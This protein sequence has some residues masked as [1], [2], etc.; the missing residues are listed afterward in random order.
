MRRL[1]VVLCV[2]FAVSASAATLQVTNANLQGWTLTASA[3]ASNL[4][5]AAAY[6]APGYETPPLGIGSVH[7]TIG[8]NGNDAAQARTNAHAGTRVDALTALSYSTFTEVDGSGGQSPYLI[9]HID[10]DGNLATADQD[11]W[12]FEPIYQGVTFF[13]SNPQGPL[14]VDTWQTWNALTGG[15]YSTSGLAG[16]GPGVNVKSITQL[17]A[18]APNATLRASGTGGVRIVTG[19]GAGAWDNFVGAADNFRL[20]TAGSDT[21]YDFEPDAPVIV[22]VTDS[23]LEN[24]TL[25]TTDNDPMTASTASSTFNTHPTIR[26]TPLGIGALRLAVGIDGNDSAEARSNRYDGLYLRDLTALS[27]YTFHDSGGSGGQAPY[28][29][30]RVDYD[31]NGTQDDLLFFEPVYQTGDF[32][33]SNIQPAVATFTWQRWEAL[34]GCWWS[35]NGTAGATPGI[36]VKPLSA[37]LEAQPDARFSTGSTGGAFRIVAGFGSGAW[38]NFIGHVDALNVA[39]TPVPNTTYDFDLDP[40]IAIGDVTQAESTLFT[41]TLTL[42][43][44][45]NY[46]I[47]V[48][49]TT[50]DGTATV[51]DLDYVPAPP[52]AVTT[53]AANSTSTT[54]VV[55]VNGD[56]KFEPNETFFVNL[57]AVTGATVSDAQ[58]IGTITNDDPQ[59]TI[60]ISDVPLAEG[61]A[62]TTNFVFNVTLSNPSATPITVN[63]ATADGTATTA[64]SDYT[65]TSGTLTFNPGVVS[66]PITVPSLGDVLFEGD[67][68]FFVNLTVPSGATIADNQGLGTIT[69]DDAQP[70]ILIND[71]TQAEGNAGTTNFIFNVTLTSGSAT[72]VTVN[73]ATADGTATTAGTDYTATSGTLTFNPGVVSQPITVLVSGDTA[74]E[75]NETFFV[76]LTVPSG[77]TIADNQGLGTITNDDG[78]FADLSLTKTGPSTVPP[79]GTIT[80]TIT[81]SNAGPQ[82]A[83]NVVVTDPIPAGTTFVSATPS[84]GTCSGTTTVICN[85]GTLANPGSATITLVVTAPMANGPVTN[86]A[87]AVSA[88]G[89]VTPAAASNT[90]FVLGAG[91]IPTLSEWMLIAL[92]M[93]LAAMAA[94]KLRA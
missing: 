6:L 51:A 9:F 92:A 93:A 82:P 52:G 85:I 83:T 40:A 29:I 70:T 62:G 76:N 46:P 91:D 5:P 80:Y 61:N 16:S 74:F 4:P 73:Y 56:T 24:W 37:I 77:A 20:A 28:I 36:G 90:A 49:Y 89:D 60:S 72:P 15:W 94:L 7:L 55:V 88:E 41:F 39:V 35:L 42:T 27:Y 21:T 47:T 53:F 1:A 71:V 78:A 13:P 45:V 66:Q 86:T 11:L 75:P 31:N 59:P 8:Q 58:A 17:L 69:N 50:A 43:H 33:P 48:P 12:F 18:A 54:I 3:P 30:L 63:Y 87:T 65:P 79:G 64:G 22:T 68:T 23:M 57:G 81:V 44:P 67:E 19:F 32:C 38:D 84:Q 25:T 14:A 34:N 2:L 26:P 10:L